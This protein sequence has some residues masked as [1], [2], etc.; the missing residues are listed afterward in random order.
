LQAALAGALGCS[1]A[2]SKDS[3]MGLG[4]GRTIELPS[5]IVVSD[6]ALTLDGGTIHLMAAN[7]TG[8]EFS[9]ML[10]TAMS[11]GTSMGVTGR[12]YFDG[13]LVP[14]R[15]E[16]EA[17]ILRL[18]SEATVQVPRLPPTRRTP[19]MAIVGEDIEQFL[20]QNPEETCRVFLRKI[21]ESV[22]SESYLRYATDEEKAIADEANRDEWERST[23]KK[24]RRTWSRSR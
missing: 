10:V 2:K 8:R 17:Q 23:G 12:L 9:V 18:L 19:R 4:T 7:E 6:C 15:S 16:R 13:V 24:K 22:Q 11:T 20:A 21:L 14:M 1:A 5:R 3:P